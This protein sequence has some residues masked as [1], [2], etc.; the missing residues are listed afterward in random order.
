MDKSGVVHVLWGVQ[1]FESSLPAHNVM[2]KGMHFCLNTYAM[3]FSEPHILEL[4]IAVFTSKKGNCTVGCSPQCTI[5]PEL[6]SVLK[7]HP[8]MQ[9]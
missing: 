2:Y 9:L 1:F 3:Q 8:P 4:E 7:N 5:T 6:P